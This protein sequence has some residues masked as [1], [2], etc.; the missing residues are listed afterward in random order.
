MLGTYTAKEARMQ[1]YLEKVRELIKQF[2]NWKVRQITRDENFE[3]NALAN[4]ASTTDVA[5]DANA[6]VIHLSHSVLDPDVNEVNFNNLTWDWRN[7]IVAFWQYG[8]VPDNK[9]KVYALRKKV[10]RYCLKQ[11]NLYRKMFG[12][13]LA[14]CLGPSQMEYVM[15]EIHEGHCGNHASG[16]SLVRTL[17][18][19]G[20]YW[21]KMEEE[22]ERFVAKYHKCQRY[23]NN[24]HRP[25][26]L[27]HPV[28]AT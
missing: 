12:G 19:A 1:Q 9:K 14:I 2:Q 15:R 20:Y 28:I 21:P 26:E 25:A 22:A 11:G 17:I 10:A 7:E 13:P 3:V 5:S 27:L 16:S 24:M 23:G 8:I 6:S 4:L 18:R